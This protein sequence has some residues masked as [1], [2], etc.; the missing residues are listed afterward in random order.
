MYNVFLSYAR[1][2]YVDEQQNV[3]PGNVIS[4]IKDALTAANITYWFDEEG[5]NHGDEF[6]RQIVRNIRTSQIFVFISTNNSNS[7]EWTNREIASAHMMRKHII[8]V[9]IDDSSYQ[10]DVLFYLSTLD[11]IDYKANPERGINEL[12]TSIRRY[13]SQV[14]E[15]ANRMREEED[16][17]RE[18]ERIRAE[19]ERRRIEQEQ[20]NL[21]SNIKIAC[22][23]MNSE[24]AKLEIDRSNLLLKV[25]RVADIEQR[26]ALRK[27]INEGGAI[28]L[29]YQREQTSMIQ[30]MQDYETLINKLQCQIKESYEKAHEPLWAIQEKERL[31]SQLQTE[32]KEVKALNEELKSEA[33][34]KQD[35]KEQQEPPIT[36]LKKW[37]WGAFFLSWIWGLH[38]KLYWQSLIVLVLWII[39][40]LQYVATLLLE[41]S[42]YRWIQNNS[43]LNTMKG[44]NPLVIAVFILIASL[45]FGV[46]GTRWAWKAKKWDNWEYFQ[47]TQKRW[48]KSIYWAVPL[49]VILAIL[50][51]YCHNK[52]LP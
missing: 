9:R 52:F 33:R 23:A 22:A 18:A 32:L 30:K 37:N 38:N 3:I 12:I 21:V 46:Y 14:Q 7:S 45:V 29:K 49:V 40:L 34:E 50:L 31:I 24:E 20:Q 16:K 19:E 6:A 8:P 47:I 27:A 2:D 1:K 43:F 42:N 11:Y 4:K 48:I 44:I 36:E 13:L 10:E 28:H 5:I 17:R 15:E 35:R 51:A 26:E 25:E 39:Q 41:F